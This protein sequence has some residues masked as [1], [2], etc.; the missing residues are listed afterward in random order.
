MESSLPPRRRGLAAIHAAVFLFG[1]PGLFAKWLAWPAVTLVLARVLFAAL[2]LGL[3]GAFT[4]RNFRPRPARDLAPLA[5]CGL[6]LAGHWTM[7]FE[8][9][10]VSSVAVGLLAYATFPVFAA[11]LE[12]LAFREKLRGGSVVLALASLLGVALIVPR[13]NLSEP[14]FRGVVWGM[15]AGLSFAVLSLFNRRLGRRHG[16]WTVAFYQDLAAAVILLP[17]GL[18]AA[19]HLAPTPRDWVLAAVLGVVCTA[20]AHT[21]FIEGLRSVR[22]QTA[23]VISSLEPAYGIVLAALFLGEVPSFRTLAGG[24]VILAAALAATRPLRSV[25]P[26]SR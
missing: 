10:R 12:P 8:A 2:A 14:V 17:L 13:F 23:A 26:L 18:A 24:L 7:F 25:S 20:G 21:L 3:A 11:F 22:A 5:L 4:R 9:V 19:P 16:S 15:G 6:I 1:F